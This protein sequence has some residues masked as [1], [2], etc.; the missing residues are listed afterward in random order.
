MTRLNS[1]L[2]LCARPLAVVLGTTLLALGVLA[3]PGGGGTQNPSEPQV[4]SSSPGDDVTS[5]PFTG[6][7]GTT[8]VGAPR[9]LRALVL[10]VA[11]TGSMTV[12][13]LAPGRVAATFSGTL[14]LTL[15][16]AVL[17]RGE[18]LVVYRGQADESGLLS[19]AGGTPSLVDSERLGLPLT[20][21]AASSLSGR[22]LRLESFVDRQATT[23]AVTAD[24]RT[25]TLAQLV[26]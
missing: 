1:L 25:V 11:G 5:L 22:W 15:D 20:R 23:V 6:P 9:A 2:K 14:Q 7:S 12:Q 18:I 8:F 3:Q 24:R 19:I 21:L 16:R 17:A 13:R 10:D 26:R 4:N